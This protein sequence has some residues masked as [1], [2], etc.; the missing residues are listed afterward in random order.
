MNTPVTFAVPARLLPCLLG[1]L[2]PVGIGSAQ[3]T[4][5]RVIEGPIDPY[6]WK[7]AD[8]AV[9]VDA[10]T[11]DLAQVFA[12][13]GPVAS[14]WY[15]HV[16]TLSDPFFEGRA[17]GSAGI[18][19]AA[20]YVEFWFRRSGL[21]PA[22]TEGEGGYRQWLTVPGGRT[23]I[24]HAAMTCG[25]R[26]LEVGGDFAVFGTS[27]SG[28]VEAPLAFAGYAIPEGPDGYDSF[29]G[30][31]DL[32]G[33]IAV[34]FRYEPLDDNGRS[35]FS[36]R[37]FSSHAA[38]R[39]KLEAVV[40]RGAV[41]VVLVNPPGSLF[42]KPGLEAVSGD[43]LGAAM[44]VPVV[45]VTEAIGREMVEAADPEGRT[46]AELRQVAD[47]GGHGAILFDVDQVCS[48]ETRVSGG[49]AETA[50]MGGVL[51]GRGDLADQ[52]VIVGAHYD[53]VGMGNFG[54][55]PGNRGR[56]HPGAD[57]N[58]SGTATVLVLADLLHDAYAKMPEDADARS[59]LFLAFTAEE[60]GLIGS[61]HFVENPFLSAQSINAMLNLDM[62]GR[63][64][65]DTIAVGGF[66]SAEGFLEDLRPTFEQSGLT[67]HADPNPR[68]PS[69]HASFYG[70]G[71]PVL[72]FY[73]GTHD[74]YH[75]PGDTGSTVNPAGGGKVVSLVR[76]VL[77][78][79]ATDSEQLVFASSRPGRVA[80]GN[81]GE[82]PPAAGG[83][84]GYASVRLGI[85]PG[86]VDEAEPGVRVE[87]VSPGT[88]AELG[89]MKG[90][91]FII[92][93]G[94][95]DLLGIMDMVERLRSH[96]PGDR[97]KMVVIR[98]GEEVELEIVF[99]ASNRAEAE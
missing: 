63:L 86:M 99:Q 90:G 40:E 32:T 33:R 42:G 15:Q 66:E 74:D 89:G 49:P 13:L 91:D 28:R 46:L 48:I 85:R 97:V 26:E 82:E 14:T 24:E 7:P 37:R 30:S 17:P 79:L 12:D 16:L 5:G 51:R 27:G 96:Q 2:I 83:G 77:M 3:G 78:H 67:I 34:V 22:F 44:S 72:F 58:A 38:I 98:D 68:G 31:A 73:T 43:A 10:E 54:S 41:G 36:R 29:G 21:E 53:H 11:V 52:W 93:W 35:R 69:D 61:R 65:S 25:E 81:A 64:R 87:S 80:R 75:A 57:D 45:Q 1:L 88:S 70:A 6:T 23:R 92:A 39:P 20:D 4:G 50:N 59:I 71:I 76:D 19:R 62:V 60:S 8:D 94:D 95:E 56:L 18:D 84:Q 9:E 47:E 55:M